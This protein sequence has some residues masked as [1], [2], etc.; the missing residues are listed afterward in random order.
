MS[1]TAELT[2]AQA[3]NVSGVPYASVFAR[4]YDEGLKLARPREEGRRDVPYYSRCQ[5]LALR[6]AKRLRKMGAAT[7]QV[8]RIVELLWPLT[9]GELEG[10][11]RAGRSWLVVMGPNVIPVLQTVEGT[12]DSPETPYTVARQRGIMVGFLDVS[13]EWAAMN[14]TL[15]ELN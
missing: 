13:Q 8:R 15:A 9:E 7:A 12:Q 10:Y 3:A 4:L 2:T 5:A 1:A 11:F 6:V 14:R